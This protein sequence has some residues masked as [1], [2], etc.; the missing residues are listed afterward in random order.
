MMQNSRN[1]SINY[2]YRAT[3]Y[4]ML[5]GP[6]NLLSGR[7]CQKKTSVHEILYYN[8][9]YLNTKQFQATHDNYVKAGSIIMPM[10]FIW[11]PKFAKTR[12]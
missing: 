5:S 4:Y 6:L 2:Q 12:V 8:P 7:I 9:V 10:I 1:N 11:F 3:L